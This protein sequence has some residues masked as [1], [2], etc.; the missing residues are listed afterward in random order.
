MIL[1]V[2]QG[3]PGEEPSRATPALQVALTKDSGR[4]LVLDWGP[5]N[6]H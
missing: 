6:P 3:A 4:W 2:T 1:R 5:V